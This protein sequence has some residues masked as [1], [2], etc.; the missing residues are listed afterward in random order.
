[1]GTMKSLAD[2]RHISAP[3]IRLASAREFLFHRAEVLLAHAQSYLVGVYILSLPLESRTQI[4]QVPS[5]ST[6]P[7]GMNTDTSAYAPGATS[8]TNTH[9]NPNYAHLPSLERS[10]L[11]FMQKTPSDNNG[12]HVRSIVASLASLNIT[13]DKLVSVSFFALCKTLM[14]RL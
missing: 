12:V 6:L 10:I 7:T 13:A 8:T 4:V 9:D 1:M 11:D 3:H 2:K 14:T 5:G